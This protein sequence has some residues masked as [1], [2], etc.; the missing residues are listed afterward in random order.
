MLIYR[1]S[2]FYV[3]CFICVFMILLSSPARATD[4]DEVFSLKL[5]YGYYDRDYDTNSKDRKQS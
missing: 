4:N 2:G 5:R 3:V 1:S